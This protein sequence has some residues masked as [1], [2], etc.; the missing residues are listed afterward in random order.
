MSLKDV[1]VKIAIATKGNVPYKEECPIDYVGTIT[2]NSNMNLSFD[3]W[4]ED[5]LRVKQKNV[6]GRIPSSNDDIIAIVLES[7]HKNEYKDVSFIHPALYIT[8]RNLQSKFKDVVSHFENDLVGG[9]TYH[10]YLIN[11]IPFQC[12]L[13]EA[14]H[15]YRTKIFKYVWD[16]G[17][18]A[19]FKRTLKDYHPS[20]IYN[21]CTVGKKTAICKSL[22]KLVDNAIHASGM[23]SSPKVHS[24][25]HPSSWSNKNNR[26]RY[27]YIDCQA[28][29]RI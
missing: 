22:R 9:K 1:F 27:F 5:T 12:S 2:V 6:L 25:A 26:C 24:G 14:T 15:K 8:G 10:V 13:N 4:F 19:S 28:F 11:A 7:P 16:N 20:I 17:G 3:F 23:N 21:L 18:E 29:K